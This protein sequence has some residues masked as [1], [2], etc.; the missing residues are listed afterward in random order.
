VTSELAQ[1]LLLTDRQWMDGRR[2]RKEIFFFRAPGVFFLQINMLSY[3]IG[4]DAMKLIGD[5]NAL[6]FFNARH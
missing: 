2:S 6:T 3:S 1:F 5:N 4:Y